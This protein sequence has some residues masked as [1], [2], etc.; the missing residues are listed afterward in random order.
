MILDNEDKVWYFTSKETYDY[1]H[2]NDK[3]V[4]LE[5]LSLSNIGECYIIIDKYGGNTPHFEIHAK[6]SDF[7]SCIKIYEPEYYFRDHSE[8]NKLTNEQIDDLVNYMNKSIGK[9]TGL[10]MIAEI[11]IRNNSNKI[12]DHYEDPYK[13]TTDYNLLKE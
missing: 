7:K 8:F 4:K 6:D 12:Y 1:M 11:W 9:F 13:V 5:G 10:R 3:Q 2:K